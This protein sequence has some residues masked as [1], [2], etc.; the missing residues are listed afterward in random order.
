[1]S[2]ICKNS[3]DNTYRVFTKG[4]PE[5]IFELCLPES[6][7]EN[8]NEMMSSYTKDGYRVIALATKELK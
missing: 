2:V 7:P 3:F 8:F 1:M 5:K 4:S 6:L